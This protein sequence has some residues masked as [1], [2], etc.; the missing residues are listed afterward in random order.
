MDAVG[1][2]CGAVLRGVGPIPVRAGL[3]SMRCGPQWLTGTYGSD[4]DAM[5]FVTRCD[6]RVHVI[7]LGEGVNVVS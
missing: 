6:G 7:A 2:R 3:S 4:G 1:V 5:G